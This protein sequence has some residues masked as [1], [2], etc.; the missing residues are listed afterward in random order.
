V[1]AASPFQ[2][3]VCVH[4]GHNLNPL[5]GT[6]TALQGLT[7]FRDEVSWNR[8][9]QQPGVL[10]LSDN[11]KDLDTLVEVASSRGQ[12]PLLILDYGNRFYDGGGLIG[13]P[14]GIAAFTRYAQFV[15]RHFKGKVD[16]FEIWNEWN[17]G[18]GAPQTPHPKGDPAAYAALLRAV[19]PAIKA[20]NPGAVVVGGAVANMDEAWIESFGQAGGF[21]F[22]DG[23]SVHPYNFSERGVRGGPESSIKWLDRIKGTVDRLSGG[24]AISLY[25]TEIGWPTHDGPH[26]VAEDVAAAYAQ[27][28]YL[29]ARA[30]PWIAGVWWYELFDDGTDPHNRE[31]H[32]G[33]LR[34]DG[35]SKAAYGALLKI[36]PLLESP[37]ALVEQTGRNGEWLLSGREADGTQV[38]ISW[39]PTDDFVYTAPWPAG[40]QLVGRGYSVLQSPDSQGT[41]RLG[42]VPTVVVK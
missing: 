23:F 28:F 27:R 11:L 21:A 2:V 6:I 26:G 33:L 10:R 7:S 8:I 20:E 22:V 42:A 32:F 39:L 36:A 16:Q 40:A 9:E 12:R 34:P 25:V 1:P 5:A 35:G 17:T 4:V 31:H 3:G 15:V 30:R 37:E 19:Y 38:T 18:S 41:P 24:R 14:A 13:S 29:L